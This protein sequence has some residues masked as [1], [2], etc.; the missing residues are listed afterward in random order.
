MGVAILESREEILE[1]EFNTLANHEFHKI[2]DEVIQETGI[3]LGKHVFPR[4]QKWL[5][6]SVKKKII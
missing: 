6:E 3:P 5:N 4:W 1:A 2:S